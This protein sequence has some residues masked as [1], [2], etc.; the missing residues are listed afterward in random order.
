MLISIIIPTYN[1]ELAIA[2]TLSSLETLSGAYEI[3]V[4]DGGSTDRTV[5]IVRAAKIPLF[6]SLQGRGLQMNLGA[7]QAQG[8][9]LLFLH[10]DT[11]LPANA[12]QL[13]LSALQ[14]AEVCGGNFSLRFSGNSFGARLLTYIYPA[15]RLLG[16]VYGDSAIFVRRKIFD[17]LNGFRAIP[18]FE[19]CDLFRRLQK[20]GEFRRMNAFVTTS[21]RRFE[22]RLGR[23]FSLWIGLQILYWL[24]VNPHR[25]AQFYKIL[26]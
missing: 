13:I 24:R 22:G 4:V 11:V 20:R 1:E 23:T 12:C 6:Q 5:E 14:Q 8:E 17:E 19:D 26:R 18:L 10:A 3:L 15:L 16:L 21:A 2:K 9:T 25:I 7:K